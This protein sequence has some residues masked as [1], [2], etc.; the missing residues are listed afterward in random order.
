MKKLKAHNAY[1]KNKS[2][3]HEMV[4]YPLDYLSFKCNEYKYDKKRTIKNL[5]HLWKNAVIHVV[6]YNKRNK[7][8]SMF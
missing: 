4:Y 7:Q 3:I 2:K 8:L 1:D 6:Q 5:M